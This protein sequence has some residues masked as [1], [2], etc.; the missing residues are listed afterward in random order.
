MTNKIS[1][2]SAV[3]SLLLFILFVS[4][5]PA[6]ANDPFLLN[7]YA[8]ELLKRGEHEK[9]LEQ[10]QKAYSLFPYNETLRKNLAEV[11]TFVGQRRM[12][13]GLFD[14][15]AANFDNAR[16]LFPDDT[17]YGVLR[18]IALYSGKHYD[19]A[20]Y[21]FERARNIVGDTVDLLYYLG[22]VYYDTGNLTGALEVWD[23]ALTMAPSNKMIRELADKSRR[24]LAVESRM[25]K[26]YS[27]RF[28][29]SYDTE[30]KSDL[31]DGILATL[32]DAYNS[33]GS[34]LAYFPIARIPVL[35]YTKKDYR[36]VTTS[37]EW[38]GGLYD[39]K[40]RLPIGGASELTPLLKGVLFH[41]YTHVVVH[42]LTNGNCPTWLNEGLAE[43]EE[44]KVFNP[45]MAELG[46]AAKQKGF[47]SFKALEGSF[48]SLS[49]RE[50]TLAYQQS[51][52]MVNFMISTYGWYKVKD[53]LVNLG[54]RMPIETAMAKALEDF[55]LNYGSVEQ[56]WQEYMKKEFGR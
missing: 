48:A 55:S 16:E 40:I 7:D 38:S 27:S 17:R 29:V 49:V 32:E 24:E 20:A 50:A 33:V 53:I 44:R 36:S 30:V 18:G 23:K 15:A 39:G 2:I 31:A 41:E 6:S 56:E 11:Y 5:C 51:Y 46:K 14:E 10:L 45:P 34:D 28:V 1:Y 47:L 52:A 9:A 21:E 43:F 42:E 4:V 26:G 13:K 22:R 25:D 54:N 19:A 37:P 12:E 35:L 3:S 8:L